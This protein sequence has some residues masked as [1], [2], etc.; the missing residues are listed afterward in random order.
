MSKIGQAKILG[1][2]GALLSL[3][4]VVP[5]VGF[6]IGLV[7][8]ILVFIAVK[9]IAEET[10]D[11]A[12]FQNY[13]MNFIFNIIAI[14]AVIGIMIMAFGISGGMSWVNAMQGKDFTDFSSF[15]DTFGSMIVGCALALL[16]A[17][18]MLLIGALYLRKSYNSIADHTKVDLFKTTGLVNLIGAATL[19][20]VIGI[21]IILIAR[22]L[23]IV[24]YFS[25]P[26]N[27]PTAPE[28]PK[29]MTP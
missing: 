29:P 3:L 27:L 15:W 21:F 10:K 14:G 4:T 7:G 28:P 20:I 23:E 24:S 19:I 26:E 5:S 22:I 11:H 12:I 17:W 13:L 8:L 9:Y 6:I 1:G 2:I 16:V 25:L 18:I